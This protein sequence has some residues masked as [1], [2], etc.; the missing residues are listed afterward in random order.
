MCTHPDL[1]QL[2]SQ[3]GLTHKSAIAGGH[4]QQ[5]ALRVPLAWSKSMIV[6]C[7]NVHEIP[8]ESRAGVFNPYKP[9]MVPEKRP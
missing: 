9:H 8:L 1:C 7:T 4:V 2:L 3:V 5:M 6:R